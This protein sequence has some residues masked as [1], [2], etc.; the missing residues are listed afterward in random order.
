MEKGVDMER[1]KFLSNK[2]I[3]LIELFGGISSQATALHELDVEFEHYRYVDFDK[4]AVKSTNAMYGTNWEATDITKIKASDL[5]V[6]DTDKYTYIMTYS[7]PCQDLSLAGKGLGMAKGSGTRSGLLWEVERLLNEMTEL[8]QVLLMENVPQVHGKKNIDSFN[9]WI[10]FLESKGYKNYWQDLKATDFGIPQS[11]NRT[12]MVS[13]LG[14]YYYNFP[15]GFKLKYLLK[16]FL[17]SEV[18]EKYYLS[19]KMISFFKN[20]E[21]KM[22]EKGNGFRFNVSDGNVVAKTI[23]TKAGS[24][25]DDNFVA[26][27]KLIQVGNLDIKGNDSIKRVYSPNGLCPTLTTMEGGNRQPKIQ[28]QKSNIKNIMADVA[29][30][31][32][33]NCGSSTSS[34]GGVVV[35]RNLKQQLANKLIEEN[36]VKAYDVI[37]HNYSTSRI[38][39]KR[40]VAKNNNISPTLDTRPDTLGVVEPNKT[41]FWN[42]GE[43]ESFQKLPLENM[44]RILKANKHDAGIIQNLRIRKLTPKDCWRLMGFRDELFDKAKSVNSNTQLYKQAGNSIVTTV[45]MAIFGELLNVEWESKVK[46]LIND[47]KE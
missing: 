5:G 11:R 21:Q 47:I 17:E 44:A 34:G 25:M 46:N 32:G 29:T 20:N 10:E 43:S 1:Q 31:L 42:Y 41:Y 28:E 8:P 33:T 7:F 14:D 13:L 36:R 15:K 16:D 3:R 9:E 6:V 2:P 12:F 26:E 23:T 19:D 39:E 18:D 27:P 37:R 35:V 22:K 24:R 38:D 40:E 45:L 30:T 4:Y